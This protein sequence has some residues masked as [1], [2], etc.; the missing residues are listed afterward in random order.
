MSELIQR[1]NRLDL[2][3]HIH[4]GKTRSVCIAIV[5]EIQALEDIECSDVHHTRRVEC[6][7]SNDPIYFNRLIDDIKGWS[8]LNFN[9]PPMNSL[10]R[11][12]RRRVN[13]TLNANTLH[14]ISSPLVTDALS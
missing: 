5:E 3:A 4:H 12:A 13:V 2:G 1:V 11:A 7:C 6:V 9:S 8:L 14:T 10:A